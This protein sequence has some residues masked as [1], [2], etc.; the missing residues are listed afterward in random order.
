MVNLARRNATRK[1]LHP[2]QVCFVHA[3]L[4][5]ALPLKSDSVD[6]V[7]SNC[8]INLLPDDGKAQVFK[9]VARVLKPGGRV[10][11]SDVSVEIT[12]SERDSPGFY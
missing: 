7:I 9:E 3:N 12:S 8:V 5:E 4:V 2:P 11:L 1:N 6:L 10:T